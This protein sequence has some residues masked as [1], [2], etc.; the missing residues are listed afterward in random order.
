MFFDIRG[1]TINYKINRNHQNLKIVHRI[2]VEL[3]TRKAAI[4]FDEENDV[5]FEV[6]N[7]WY[8]LF[9]VIRE[10]IKDIS[11]NAILYHDQSDDLVQMVSDILNECLRPHLTRYQ[12]K[13]R[14]WYEEE[15]NDPKNRG[16][17]PQE[18]QRKYP[19]YNDLIKDMKEVN[20]L[21]IKYKQ[22]FEKFISISKK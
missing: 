22:E 15:L 4:S 3:I 13:F 5:I 10:E 12:S 1:S 18:I 7:S 6:Y 2:Y 14:K 11:D 21:L 16:K 20:E 8:S 17:D 9:K 19:Q